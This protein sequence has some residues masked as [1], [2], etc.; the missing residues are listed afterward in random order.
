MIYLRPLCLAVAAVLLT[1]CSSGDSRA[2]EVDSALRAFDEGNI[3]YRQGDYRGAV[4]SYERAKNAGFE[5]GALYFNMGNAY[6]RL[7]AVGQAVRYYEKAA[8]LLDDSPELA[9]NLQIVRERT[10]DQFSRL[11]EPFWRP[12][13]SAVVRLL[14]VSG[15]VVLG[16]V[17]YVA[18]AGAI[19]LRIRG[20]QTP[21]RRRIAAASAVLAVVFLTAGFTASVERETAS[22]AVILIDEVTLLDGPAG[23]RSD[24]EIHEGLVVHI[25]EQDAEWVQVRLPNGATGWLRNEAI[26]RI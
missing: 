1:L 23:T 14:G 18:A 9:H 3:R 10:T 24:L 4:D 25:V 7:D 13:W 2:Q 22:R 20:G 6:F 17:F 5:S 11:P 19:A 8:V 16:I 26:G 15:L 12:W 21:W